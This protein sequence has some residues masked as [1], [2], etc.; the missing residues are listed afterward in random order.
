MP[1]RGILQTVIEIAGGKYPCTFK[2]TEGVE[3]KGVLGRDFLHAHRANISFETQMLELTD[4]AS[5]NFSVDLIAVVAPNTCVIPLR[6][7]TVLP[8]TVRSHLAWYH[9]TG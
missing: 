6:S 3:Y 4:P 5:T 2:V 9:W 8:A 1:I 7:E